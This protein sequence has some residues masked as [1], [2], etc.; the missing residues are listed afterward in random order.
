MGILL[1]LVGEARIL[2]SMMFG[3]L[4]LACCC[5]G[6]PSPTCVMLIVSQSGAAIVSF[7]VLFECA[8]GIIFELGDVASMMGSTMLGLSLVD[9]R[10]VAGFW[11][12][13]VM[14]GGA[15]P[16]VLFLFFLEV[17]ARGFFHFCSCSWICC[18]CYWWIHLAHPLRCFPTL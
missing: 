4:F 15:V 2:G 13:V 17:I 8:I 7:S 1:K 10:L 9:L 16:G 3:C 14:M 6:K 5:A 11:L 12:C 18:C